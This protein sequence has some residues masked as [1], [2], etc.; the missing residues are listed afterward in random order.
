MFT[1]HRIISKDDYSNL[2]YNLASSFSTNALK[3]HSLCPRLHHFCSAIIEWQWEGTLPSE[4]PLL[5]SRS[6]A[7]ELYR[8]LA[9]DNVQNHAQI[10]A[11]LWNKQR[12]T[13]LSWTENMCALNLKRRKKVFHWCARCLGYFLFLLKT[14]LDVL[15]LL[16]F[17]LCFLVLGSIKSLI[18]VTSHTP[19]SSQLGLTWTRYSLD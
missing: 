15:L 11:A 14:G 17:L 2:L 12:N 18:I 1:R 8:C 10:C 16:L 9:N 5:S 19:S 7:Q 3:Q 4:S 13:D 6:W